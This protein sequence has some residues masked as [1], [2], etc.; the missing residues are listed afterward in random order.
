MS[1]LAHTIAVDQRFFDELIIKAYPNIKSHQIDWM[2]VL[3]VD[4]VVQIETLLEKA[5]SEVANLKRC[6]VY[7]M[8]FIDGSDAKKCTVRSHGTGKS[9]YGAPVRGVHSKAGKLRIMCYER[10]LDRFYY[11]VIPNCAFGHIKST[12]NIDI[13]FELDGTP[14]RVPL[15][16]LKYSNWWDYEV[17]DF[18]AMSTK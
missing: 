10:Q 13:P 17:A 9:Q 1:T 15:R 12:G 3:L 6:S 16:M 2:K 7:G 8:D 11:F 18:N 14:R 4:G 5:I